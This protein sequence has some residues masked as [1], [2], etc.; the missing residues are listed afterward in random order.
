LVHGLLVYD[1][2]FGKRHWTRFSRIFKIDAS[3]HGPGFIFPRVHKGEPNENEIDEE[4]NK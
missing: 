3:S 2:I 4:T 1:D